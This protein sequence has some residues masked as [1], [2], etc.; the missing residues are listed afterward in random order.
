MDLIL[1]D[2]TRPTL[3]KDALYQYARGGSS[4]S[5]P[6]IRLA[7]A[8]ARRWGNIASGIK[9]V[10]RADGYSECVAYAWDLETGYYDERQYQVRHWRDTKSGGYQLTDER[11]IYELVAN[12]GQR[13][14]RAVLLT[15][16]DGE[17]IEA[18]VEQ[19]EQTLKASA[20][21]SPDGLKKLAEAF[22]T[23]GVTREQ[24][25]A[26][27]QCRLEAIRPA[28]I[29]QL[30]K[31]YASLHDEMSAPKDWF[32]PVEG[33]AVLRAGANPAPSQQPTARAAPK[34]RAKAPE[35]VA[36]VAPEP[37][38][39][40]FEGYLQ[41]ESGDVIEGPIT[42]PDMWIDRLDQLMKDAFPADREK[43]WDNNLE[44]IAKLSLDLTS[45]LGSRLSVMGMDLV[46]PDH[47]G[48]EQPQQA[49]VPVRWPDDWAKDVGAVEM[50]LKEMKTLKNGNA[51]TAYMGSITQTKLIDRLIAE[52]KG[53][54]LDYFR[55]ETAK[56]V[57]GKA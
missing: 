8:L 39:A 46:Q 21:T 37:E 6:S 42:D 16:I 18:A 36:E 33:A 43:I 49:S 44:V 7:E 55:S 29:V 47:E 3:A 23:F 2:C 25:E 19:C 32:T 56:I 54:L 5:G 13:R 15:V 35:P 28:Q 48:S 11:D 24:I 10:S 40:A 26:R 45:P 4:I 12:L 22:A 57:E 53:V 9:E 52:N 30:R 50:R 38:A 27:C 34:P 17:V 31:I 41:D 20:D 1:R 14:K 51:V